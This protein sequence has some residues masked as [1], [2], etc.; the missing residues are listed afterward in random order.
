MVA[1]KSLPH[2]HAKIIAAMDDLNRLNEDQSG[3]VFST[4]LRELKETLSKRGRMGSLVGQ[5]D[6][7]KRGNAGE[8]ALA[9]VAVRFSCCSDEE[10]QM[11]S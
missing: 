7:L 5:S 8:V 10:A 2:G 1:C 11:A 6:D 4:W 9:D 3:A